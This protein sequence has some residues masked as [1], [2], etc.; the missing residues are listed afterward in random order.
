MDILLNFH[1]SVGGCFQ[2]FIPTD[3]LGEVDQ[4]IKNSL[5][6]DKAT[7]QMIAGN[8]TPDELLEMVEPV[9]SN[10]DDYIQEI[11]ENLTEIYLV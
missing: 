11:E 2:L 4:A 6:V 1:R 10:M 9:I 5:L 3:P 8:I 7:K